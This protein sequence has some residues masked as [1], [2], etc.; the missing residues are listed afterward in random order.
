MRALTNPIPVTGNPAIDKIIAKWI[1]GMETR[2]EVEFVLWTAM[3]N[4]TIPT[5]DDDGNHWTPKK[6]MGYALMITPHC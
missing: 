5:V 4:G 1:M 6:I 3:L 2:S